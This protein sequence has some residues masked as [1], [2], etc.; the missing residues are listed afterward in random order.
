V[1]SVIIL[2]LA[3][4]FRAFAE[5]ARVTALIVQGDAEDRLSHTNAALVAFQQAEKIEPDNMGVL[6]RIS[7]QYSDLVGTTKVE[8]LARQMGD[9]ALDYGK[10]AVDLDAKSA[11]A[12]LNLAVCYGKLTDFVG[13]KLKLDYSK[14]IRDE[15]QK[16]LELDPSDDFAWH[17]MGRWNAG[18][19]NVGAVLKTLARFVYGGLP[20]A[21]NEEAVRCLKKATELAPQRIIHHAE[22]AR[23]Y[24]LM[25][26]T[27]L[28]AQEWQNVLG[29]KASDGEDE[30]Y[31]KEARLALEVRRPERG[32]GSRMLSGSSRPS[33]T[34]Q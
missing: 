8:D 20:E 5:D 7:K 31:Q 16:S 9:K 21:S 26:K 3:F 18:V 33:N 15:T 25:G 22:L 28:A 24:K 6:L 30:S 12:H 1:K 14:L 10:R 4:A 27:D 13:N 2:V 23:I 29:L 19:A 34:P 32:G 11:K 17:V